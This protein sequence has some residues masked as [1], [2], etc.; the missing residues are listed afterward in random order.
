MFPPVYPNVWEH[1]AGLDGEV[2]RVGVEVG[3]L[4]G[5]GRNLGGHVVNLDRE[6]TNLDE[7]VGNLGGEVR[8]VGV[9]RRNVGVDVVQVLV[10]RQRPGGAVGDRPPGRRWHRIEGWLAARD[11]LRTFG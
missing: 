6:V 4:G 11:P 7:E 8:G 5:E 9:G 1:V 10:D 3:G 2:Q